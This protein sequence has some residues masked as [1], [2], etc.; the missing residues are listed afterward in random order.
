MIQH[1][2]GDDRLLSLAAGRLTTGAGLLVSVHL[3]GC[4]DCR[5]RLHTLQSLG[6]VVLEESEP[7]APAPGAW[8]RTLARIDAPVPPVDAPAAAQPPEA[9]PPDVQWPASLRGC[10]VS[11]WH[12]MGPGMRFARLQVPRS[13]EGSLF[14][15][16]IG[17]GRSLPRH[18][19]Q[20][21]ELTQ[22]LS[23]SFDDG[24][25]VLA[26]GD[27]DDADGGVHHQPVVRAGDECICLAYLDAPLRFDGRI[28]GMVGG[29]VGL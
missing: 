6:G 13:A 11:K 10:S 22:V 25:I 29:W 23:G 19:H 5:A 1:H 7:A 15:L 9:W 26:A 4:G 14:L 17:P 16:R 8:E 28:A 20:G 27:F 21:T 18:T 2:P 3:E 12:W 24:R